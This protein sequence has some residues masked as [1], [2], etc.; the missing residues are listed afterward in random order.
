MD[1]LV[2]DQTP[3]EF[4]KELI[5]KVLRRQKV[6]S[7]PLSSY[8]LVHLLETFLRRDGLYA[9][10]GVGEDPQLAEIFCRALNANG[11]RKSALF[12]MTGDLSLFISGFFSD[13]LMR[14]TADATYYAQIGGYAYGMLGRSSRR[15]TVSEVFQELS[16]KF[17]QFADVLSEVSEMSSITNNKGLLRLYEKWLRTGSERCAA[18]LKRE[19]VL[20]VPLSK[21]VH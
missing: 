21:Q 19:G 15:P 11:R 2:Q 9:E 13:S 16:D 14:K 3:A 7:S 6:S 1:H 12:K 4:F 5:D 17:S 20:L 10:L 18:L 8:Y